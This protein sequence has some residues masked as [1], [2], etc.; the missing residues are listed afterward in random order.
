M[1]RDMI[2]HTTHDATTASAQ[3]PSSHHGRA[4]RGNKTRTRGSD[5]GDHMG[6]DM[7]DE[8]IKIDKPLMAH[9][10]YTASIRVGPRNS[11][12]IAMA[13]R[14]IWLGIPLFPVSIMLP[15][16]RSAETNRAPPDPPEAEA[17]SAAGHNAEYARDATSLGSVSRYGL[18]N[19]TRHG[20]RSINRTT[21]TRG[22]M[23]RPN[24]SIS[25]SS[26]NGWTDTVVDLETS[27]GGGS[28]CT[29]P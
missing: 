29:S 13:Q 4:A 28:D 25:T 15:P 17:E 10:R 9:N 22:M 12:E 23:G 7:I 14:G 26:G 3:H 19:Q 21:D 24:L 20:G 6:C 1:H 27:H 11:S 16:P 2:E 8:L 5:L 18:T